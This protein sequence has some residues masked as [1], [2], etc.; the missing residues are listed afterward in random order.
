MI[1]FIR[2]LAFG[3]PR[4]HAISDKLEQWPAAHSLQIKWLG[5]I[6]DRR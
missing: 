1:V 5:R 2:R 4:S 3:R 6:V